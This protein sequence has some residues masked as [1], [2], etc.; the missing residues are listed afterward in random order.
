MALEFENNLV[1][2][3]LKKTFGNL[4]FVKVLNARMMY[5][6]DR[7]PTGEI[8]ERRIEVSSDVQQSTFEVSLP[9]SADLEGLK[10]MEPIELENVTI[11]P[12]AMIDE[13]A[14]G[15][16]PDSGVKVRAEKIRKVGSSRPAQQAQAAQ[17]NDKGKNQAAN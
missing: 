3:N 12:W 17:N 2:A 15:N 9:A 16:V 8:S 6:E 10:W 7:N 5:D 13:D 11:R 14:F 4:F 1:P